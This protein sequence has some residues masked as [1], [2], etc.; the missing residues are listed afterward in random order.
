MG[1]AKRVVATVRAVVKR[2]KADRVPDASAAVT[3]WVV[4]SLAPMAL[5]AAALLG[6]LGAVETRLAIGRD[7]HGEDHRR[8]LD[9]GQQARRTLAQERRIEARLAVRQIERLAPRPSLDI[10]CI[11]VLDEPRD[12]GDRIMEQ[13][14]RP[15]LLDR[16][17]LVEIGRRRGIERHEAHRSAIDMRRER[18]LR[19]RLRRGEHLGC[20][21]RRH[22]K[23][24]TDRAQPSGERTVGI[25]ERLHRAVMPGNSPKS[26]WRTAHTPR[27]I[28]AHTMYGHHMK[29]TAPATPTSVTAAASPMTPPTNCFMATERLVCA[30]K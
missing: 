12:I 29:A 10:E 11:A 15:G 3:Y 8:A 1:T 9:I 16:E 23:F 7:P 6:T 13:H 24:I 5:A 27:A 19:R 26:E 14:V 18:P 20:E 28:A 17:R 21:P 30:R 2:A 25:D 4:L 22:G